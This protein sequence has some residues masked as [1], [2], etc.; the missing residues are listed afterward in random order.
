MCLPWLAEG[1]APQQATTNT[2]PLAES[3]KNTDSD[4]DEDEDDELSRALHTLIQENRALREKL[5]QYKSITP[6]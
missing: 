5:T 1:N 6:N 3:D 2:S 4:E